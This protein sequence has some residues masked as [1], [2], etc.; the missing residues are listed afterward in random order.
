MATDEAARSPAAEEEASAD[1]RSRR[2]Q[3]TRQAIIDAHM[4]L[5]LEGDLQPTANRVADRAGVSLRAVWSHFKDL[6][7]LFAAAGEKTLEIQFSSYRPIPV[8]QPLEKRVAQFAAQR[9]RMLES[10]AGASRAAQVRINFSRQL[11]ENRAAHNEKMREEIE[12]LFKPELARARARREELVNALLAAT[13]WPVW[14][15]CR[16]DLGLSFDESAAV[17]HRTV[18]G[19][20]GVTRRARLPRTGDG[21]ST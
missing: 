8:D 5:M 10:I 20:L 1:G 12:Q 4:E 16:D 6:E 18:A 17:M 13:T 2:A 19:L 14:M 15:G 3:R 21:R 9:A 7:A 11:Q